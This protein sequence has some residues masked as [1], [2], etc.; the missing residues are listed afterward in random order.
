MMHMK[1]TTYRTALFAALTLLAVA[2]KTP[3]GQPEKPVNFVI[4]AP[5]EQSVAPG[6]SM[7]LSF[8]APADW[9]ASVSKES[10][11]W[12]WFDDSGIK[13]YTLSGKAGDIR[14]TL[15]VSDE[16]EFDQQRVCVLTV[17]CGG[18][19]A[20]LARITKTC[21]SRTLAVYAAVPDAQG[22]YHLGD[23]GY[24]YSAEAASS[25]AL[26]WP[27]GLSGFTLPVKVSANY[28]WSI[29]SYPDWVN[30]SLTSGAAGQSVDLRLVGEG[31]H[32]PYD[33][34]SGMLRFMD[35]DTQAETFE[36]PVTIPGYKDILQVQC[37]GKLQFNLLGQ[38]NN[39]GNWTSEGALAWITAPEDVVFCATSEVDGKTVLDPARQ[40]IVFNAEPWDVT[41]GS[42][43]QNRRVN[44]AAQ[45]NNAAPRNAALLALPSYVKLGDVLA[46]D[47]SVKPSYAS[48][49]F[50]SATQAGMDPE[51]GWGRLSPVNSDYVMGVRGASFKRIPTY[52]EFETYELR[53]NSAVSSEYA[54]IISLTSIGSISY[55]GS[56]GV[57]KNEDGRFE[58]S[59]PSEDTKSLF[60]I[61]Y[62]ADDAQASV[63]VLLRDESGKL[64][65]VVRC[66]V[67]SSFWPAVDYRD[68]Y[69]SMTDFYDEESDP[70][71]QMLPHDVELEE[72]SSGAVYDSYKDLDIPIWKLTYK[73][74]YSS[75]NAMIYI[76]PVKSDDQS[77]FEY[78]P[79]DSWLRAEPGEFEIESENISKPYLHVFMSDTEA[80]KGREGYIVLKC[81]GQPVMVLVCVREFI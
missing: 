78:H 49:V 61:L 48:Y 3:A 52:D 17:S 46:A 76:P 71:G 73:T 35:L 53:Y 50:A 75:Y 56:D 23:N 36:I 77:S 62:D 31:A 67:D 25:L 37:D 44:I 81:S 15:C 63:D 16:E 45:P 32:Y 30:P 6:Q 19:S 11:A 59:Y 20:E 9:T 27:A 70:D 12:F 65:A 39:D 38:F 64:F 41:D 1:I 10:A 79:A 72:L 60:K 42:K 74:K 4:P 14:L 58:L 18:K 34:A 21:K 57:E 2:C 55:R 51:A 28:N 69:F 24:E 80:D 26:T 40:W 43:I 7:E 66:T 13:Q 5:V 54:D 22:Y 33:A 68:I 29:C 8:K 47:G